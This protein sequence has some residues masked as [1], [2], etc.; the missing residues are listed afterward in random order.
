MSTYTINNTTANTGTITLNSGAGVGGLTNQPLGNI[1]ISGGG[2]G[3]DSVPT[4]YGAN[5]G[6]GVVIIRFP[7]Y[8]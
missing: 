5:G 1:T 3:G 4:N 7:S 6:S 2:F 8:F